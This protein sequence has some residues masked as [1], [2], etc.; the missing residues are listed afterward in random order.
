MLGIHRDARHI[1]MDERIWISNQWNR[2]DM[3]LVVLAV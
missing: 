3:P 1:D 2:W